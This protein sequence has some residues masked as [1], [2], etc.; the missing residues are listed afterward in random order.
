MAP[1][2]NCK[3][4]KELFAIEKNSNTHALEV[5]KFVCRRFTYT[6]DRCMPT[7]AWRP[8]HFYSCCKINFTGSS[9][10]LFS[11]WRWAGDWG[12]GKGLI[13]KRERSGKSLILTIKPPRLIEAQTQLIWVSKHISITIDIFMSRE[14][15]FAPEYRSGFLSMCVMFSAQFSSYPLS[16][17]AE[18]LLN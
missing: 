13:V 16:L 17:K 1:F 18:L 4:N 6:R 10:Y 7:F 14:F 5:I 15:P 3:R 2:E 12:T 11:R 9:Y 8:K